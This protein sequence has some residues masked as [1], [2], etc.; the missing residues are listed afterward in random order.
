MSLVATILDPVDT[1][2]PPCTVAT[3]IPKGS[4]CS[5]VLVNLQPVHYVGGLLD[6]H[7][8]TGDE[9]QTPHIPFLGPNSSRVMV[10]PPQEGGAPVQIARMGDSYGADAGVCGVII[11]PK[12]NTTVF[13]Y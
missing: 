2:H 11:A 3:I 1:L 12:T 4:G 5:N 9:C 6:I 7:P 8:W 10:Y 13:A